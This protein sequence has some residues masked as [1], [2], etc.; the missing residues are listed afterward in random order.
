MLIF[1]LGTGRCGTGSLA[2][3]LGLSHESALLP[4]E[5]DEVRFRQVWSFVCRHGG[6]VGF[7]WINYVDR[8]LALEPS[9]RF[10]CLE[11]D[12]AA[13]L[14]S[15]A[16]VQTGRDRLELQAAWRRPDDRK[17]QVIDLLPRRDDL[18]ID[19]ALAHYY[20]GYMAE[21]RRLARAHPSRFRIFASPAVLRERKAQRELLRFAK[22]RQPVRRDATV[23][24]GTS[25]RKAWMHNIVNGR[26]MEAIRRG[27]RKIE[28]PN[29]ILEHHGVDASQ[30]LRVNVC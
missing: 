10:I 8:V 21:A 20:D 29:E 6:D 27:E 25:E 28:I 26:A 24:M 5:P 23:H 1:G 22:L 2:E 17:V 15:W 13:T 9:A 3:I 7:Y 18:P 4:W 16:K 19:E 30:M 14:R 11:R 12:R